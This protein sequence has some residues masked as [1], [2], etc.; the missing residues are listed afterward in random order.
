MVILPI[1]LQA[2]ILSIVG[3]HSPF[4]DE[5]VG[6]NEKLD[7]SKSNWIKVQDAAMV[8]EE[9]PGKVAQAFRLF[10]QGHGYCHNVRKL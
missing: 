10:L 9:K 4:V 8:V 7:P 1:F 3:A 5:T 2:P 6:L